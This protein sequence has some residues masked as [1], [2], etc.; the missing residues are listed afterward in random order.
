ME[1]AERII[2]EIN[3]EAEQK[4]QYLL[5][6]AQEEANRIRE[7][8][9]KRAE[10]RAEWILRKAQ[11]QAEIEKQRIIAGAKLEVRKRRLALQEKLIQEVITT[12]HERLSQ[13]PDEEYFPMLVDLASEA[14]D[15]LGMPK[16][17]I[18]S[19]ERTLKLLKARK[20]E[21][22]SAVAEKVGR[23]VE[24]DIGE[25]INTIGGVMVESEDGS[26]RVDNTF[27]ARMERFE[28]DLRARIAKA[29]FG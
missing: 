22:E 16:A 7:E 29:L 6:E 13:L 12:L 20:D 23:K 21:F 15:E 2:Q 24:M 4:I 3:R 1:G 14:V 26:V 25:P 10:A 11:T 17:R 8:A 18:L 9:K 19:N 28:S 27:E 5:S